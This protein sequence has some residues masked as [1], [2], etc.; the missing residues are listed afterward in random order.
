MMKY[1]VYNLSNQGM[2]VFNSKEELIRWFAYRNS[3]VFWSKKMRN[4]LFDEVAM[5]W[6]DTK[7]N[8]IWDNGSMKY[9][10]GKLPRTLMFFDEYDRIIDPR[11]FKDE[12]LNY[13]FSNKG[14]HYKRYEKYEFRRGPVPGIHRFSSGRYYRRMRTTQERRNSSDLE[15]KSYIRGKRSVRNLLN[16]WDD[17]PR[18]VDHSWKAKKIKKQWM[19][20]LK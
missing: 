7:Y 12:I 11:T 9:I 19:K 20:H 3:T 13:E 2:H 1:Y 16:N 8:P 18:N 5:N 10:N 15:I 6:N 4:P 17:I 14:Y